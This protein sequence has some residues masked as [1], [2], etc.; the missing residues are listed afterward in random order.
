M[1]HRDILASFKRFSAET[2]SSDIVCALLT[3]AEVIADKHILDQPSA[4]NFGHELSLALRFA[5]V[6][7]AVEGAIALDGSVETHQDR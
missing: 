1:E 7:V 5:P 6:P 2:Q 3:L 4:E